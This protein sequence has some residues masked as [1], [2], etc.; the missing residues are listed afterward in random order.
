[1]VIRISVVTFFIGIE[2]AVSTR[3]RGFELAGRTTAIAGF[4]VT[5]ITF[6][7]AVEFAIS[8]KTN[9]RDAAI[10]KVTKER[11]VSPAAGC[12]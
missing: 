10:T 9:G 11:N 4:N 3:E 12:T 1:L 2:L 6:F 7:A 5:V 8:T